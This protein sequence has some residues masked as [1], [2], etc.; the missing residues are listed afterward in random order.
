MLA[1]KPLPGRANRDDHGTDFLSDAGVGVGNGLLR[2]RRV[3]PG[4]G[5][6]EDSSCASALDRLVE[7][8]DVLVHALRILDRKRA[9]LLEDNGVVVAILDR[10]DGKARV[11]VVS[12]R[13]AARANQ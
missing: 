2:F 13:G 9:L 4:P 5:H 7:E 6:I 10:F 11:P 8:P 1:E 3:P 12:K